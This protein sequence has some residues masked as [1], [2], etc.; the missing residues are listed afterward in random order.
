MTS[1][2]PASQNKTISTSSGAATTQDLNRDASTPI[3]T[4]APTRH[5][6]GADAEQKN[7]TSA[8][9]EEKTDV[10]AENAIPAAEA[11]QQ[12]TREYLKGW[13]LYTL[14]FALCLSLLLSTLETTIVST[15]LISISNALGGFD[16]RD[17]VVTSYL[18]TYTGRK[19]LLLLAL[20]FFTVFSIICGSIYNMVHLVIFRAFQGV[21]ASGI[22]AMVTVIQPEMVPPENWGNVIA[23][24]S[25]VMVMSSVLGPVLGG[26]INDHS[27][28][29]WVFLLNAPA[30]VIATGLIAFFMPNHF[31]EIRRPSTANSTGLRAKLSRA[32]LARLDVGGAALLLS[33]SVL[34]VFAFEEAGS[35]YGWA[36][37]AILASLIIGAALFVGFLGWEKFIGREGSVQEP[38]FPLRLLK[39]RIFAALIAV[40][41]FTGPPFMTVLINLPQRFQAVDGQSAFQAGI[42]MLPLLLSSPVATA[43]AGQLAAKFKVPPFYLILFAASLQM[44]GL[45]LASS[46]K[47]VSGNEMYGYEV[48]M[49]FGFGMGLVSLLI[50][51]PMVVDRADLGVAMGAITQVRV[52]GG[53]IGL[54][55]SATVLNNYT[56]SRLQAIL[57]LEELHQISESV[58]YINAL[59]DVT[60][61]TVKQI[62]ADGYN[63]QMRTMLYFNIVVFVGSLL[64]WE[65]NLRSAAT[66]QGY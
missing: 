2:D 55:I 25:M 58:Q 14:T 22:Y 36:S 66:V 4:A 37:P 59:P 18:I 56:N 45:G 31:P 34:I 23:V 33:S 12:P 27:S 24:T 50:F 49:G 47:Y 62:F 43:V 41:F 3:L 13:R 38:V 21:G 42:R 29:R 11:S 52:L 9:E 26:V 39:D 15:S 44:V 30:G 51:T 7:N 54:A 6:G 60:R 28:W 17:W 48:I 64:L 16:Q 53:T 57:T 46:V 5:Q 8:P 10:S 61:D 35:R 32:S 20:A 65:R 63:E 1:D 40:A 19:W